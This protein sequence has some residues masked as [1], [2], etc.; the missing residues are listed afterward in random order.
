M[1]CPGKINLFHAPGGPGIRVD[2]HMFTSYI[3]PPNYDSLLGKLIAFADNREEAINRMNT[4]LDEII[5]DGIKTNIPLHQRMM[6]DPNFR[7]GQQSIHYLEKKLN[8]I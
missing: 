8:K 1:P 3:V 6:N 4:A 2:S 7:K 5:I